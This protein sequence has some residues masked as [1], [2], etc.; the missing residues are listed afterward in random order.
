MTTQVYAGF[1]LRKAK[2][3]WNIAG[4]TDGTNPNILSELTWDKLDIVEL[5]LG[6]RSYMEH[7]IYLGG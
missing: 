7:G 3:D 1:S 4:Q 2:L 6:F 5:N